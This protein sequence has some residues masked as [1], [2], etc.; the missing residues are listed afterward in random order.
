MQFR[1]FVCLLYFR[2]FFKQKNK[3]VLARDTN[4][5]YLWLWLATWMYFYTPSAH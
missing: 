3:G 2:S 4:V 5:F 1:P